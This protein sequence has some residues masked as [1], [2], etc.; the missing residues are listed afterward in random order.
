MTPV[1]E[2]GKISLIEIGVDSFAAAFDEASLAVSAPDRLQNLVEQIVR[3]DQVGLHVFG[4]GEHH[5]R[6]MLD[7]ARAVILGAAAA[8]TEKIRLTRA[9]RVS[10]CGDPP[11]V[12]QNFATVDLLPRVSAARAVGRGSCTESVLFCS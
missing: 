2:W 6:E 7:S 5:R 4:I 1:A 9:V 12:F 11:R 3:A 8:R 10:S